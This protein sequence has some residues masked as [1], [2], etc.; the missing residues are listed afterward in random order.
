MM[1]HKRLRLTQIALSLSL[2]LAAASTF[3]QNTTS[4]IGGRISG[5][6]GTPAAGATVS[7]LHVESGSVSSVTTDAQGRYVARGLRAGGPY[8]ITITKNGVTEKR[9]NVFVALA[10]TT[11]LDAQLGQAMQTVTVTGSNVRNDR[12]S[13]T[14]MGTGTNIGPTELAIQASINRN[15]QDYARTD[16]RVAQTDKERG[17]MSVAGQN[18]RYNSMTID[19]VSVSDTFGLEASGSPTAKQP[20]SIEAIQSVQVNVAN[21]D[22]TQKGYT[23]GNIN[24]VTKSGTNNVKGSVYYVFRNDK[25]AGDRYNASTGDYSAPAPFK[26]TTKGATVGGPL[27]KDKLFIFAG[28]EKLESTKATPGYGPI[29][30]SLTN[31]AITPAAI[32]QA[33]SIA[34]NTY[35]M[36]IGTLD[37][38]SGTTLNVTDKLLKFDWNINDDHRA[39]FRWSKTEQTEPFF[40]GSTNTAISLNSQWY[41]QNKVLETKVAQL[42]SDWTPTFS[43]EVKV[44]SRDYDSVP[45]NNSMLPS[46][47]LSFVGPLPDGAP[48]GTST[49]S[50]SLNFGTENS[51]HRNTLATKTDDY[52]VG[53]NW[54]LGE[55]EVKFGFDYQK[56]EVNNAFLQN[57]YGTYSFGCVPNID[58]QFNGGKPLTSCDAKV[59]AAAIEQAVLENFRRGRPSSIQSQ[60]AN[61]GYSLE[62]AV[63]KFTMKDTGVF[64]QDTWTISPRLTVTGGVRVDRIDVPERPIANAAVAAATVAR[65]SQYGQQTGGFGLDNTNTFDG[66]KLW[67]P[68]LG[69]NYN[70]DTVRRTQIRGG[71]GLFQGAALN[72]W[73]G[74]PF[75]N[76]GL[77]TSTY[78]CGTSGFGACQYVDGSFSADP[79]KPVT[80]GTAPAANVDILAAGLRQP[81]VWKA[82]IAV[83]HELPWQNIVVSAEYLKTDVRD[84]VYYRNVNLGEATAIGTDGRELYHTRQG[85]DMNCWSLTGSR[86]TTGASCV[87]NRSRSGANA[88]FGNV[89]VAT[90]TKQ[91]GSNLATLSFSRPM[92][93]GLGWS[94]AYTY[95]EAKEVSPLTSSTSNSNWTGRSI[96]NPNEEVVANSSYLV[97]D[98]INAVVNFRKRFFSSYNTTFGLFYEG[99]SGKPFSWTFNNDMNGDDLG[100]ND[101]MYIPRGP[102]SGEVVFRGDT[103]TNHANEDRFWAVVDQYR[104][105]RNSKGKI[106][107]RNNSFAPW[108]NSFDVRVSQEVPGFW[109]GHKG[110]ITFDIFNVGNLLNK[111]WGRINEVAFQSA[112]GQARSFVDFAGVDAQGRYIYQM[113]DQVEDYTVRQTKGESQW[114]LQATVKYEF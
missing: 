112:G 113:R 3:A 111:K 16:P 19:G 72:V 29:G 38:P 94:V 54:L 95:T 36:D 51:R 84:A 103:A 33:Q 62:D 13:K 100:G 24:A 90:N 65:T 106:V 109:T 2:A 78:I 96:V 59:G 7:I 23:G 8:T 70:F 77:A 46:M 67:Q 20:I 71:V 114:A 83:D 40:A 79:S 74:N 82:N 26:E 88:A 45:K 101:L 11:S 73:L 63:A 5:A 56:N 61:P 55:H 12:F 68:R 58:Y 69:F 49:G 27:I 30:S 17:E 18:S 53:A 80:K 52:Y 105:L 102:G 35:G 39:M 60:V 21:Y 110:V 89:L 28:Y 107:D 6:D 43:T 104:G 86:I 41:Q 4:A 1:N 87:G 47:N 48:A 93:S 66:Q 98:R 92:I 42:N 44:S 15:L 99:R 50:R 97:K 34:K 85:Y 22:V 64:V 76:N 10:E 25:L 57:I 108:T 91:G 9:E 32:A 31:L 81:S 14:T 37:V 75:Q